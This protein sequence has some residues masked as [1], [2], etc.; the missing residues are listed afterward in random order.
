MFKN[1]PAFTGFSAPD[2]QAEKK[3]Y[4][5]TL[6]LD[7]HEE[8]EMGLSIKLATGGIVFIYPK[9]NHEPATYTTLNFPVENID[10]AVAQ[11][12]H[13]GVQFE[14]YEGMQQDEHG[15]ARGIAANM[16]PDIAWFKDPAGNILAVLQEK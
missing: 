13:K 8:G 6:G 7:V 9:E 5:E 11:L 3:F 10:E 14:R 16:G 4:E 1:S 12:K 2:I 15:I